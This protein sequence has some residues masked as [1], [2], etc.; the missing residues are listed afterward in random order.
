MC[1]E[2]YST[3]YVLRCVILESN[4]E[5]DV[6]CDNRWILCGFIYLLHWHWNNLF[7]STNV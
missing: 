3:I 7:N 6:E 4:V 1:H 2:I 5:W